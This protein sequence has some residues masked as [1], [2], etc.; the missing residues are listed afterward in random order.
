[1]LGTDPARHVVPFQAAARELGLSAATLRRMCKEGSG[2]TLL[3]LSE[4]RLGVRR[5]DLDAW[6]K[7]R[8]IGAE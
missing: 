7:T 6:L 5:G 3:R 4:R 1:M 2:P 8:E